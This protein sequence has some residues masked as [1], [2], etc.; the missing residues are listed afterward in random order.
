VVVPTA[1]VEMPSGVSAE[2]V[3]DMSWPA[4][5]CLPFDLSTMTLTP[6]SASA[7]R[8]AQSSSVRTFMFWALAASGRFSVMTPTW[9]T[10]SYST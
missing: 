4:E 3:D 6:G 2:S 8:Q 5:K 1:S 10:T 7:C 9:S